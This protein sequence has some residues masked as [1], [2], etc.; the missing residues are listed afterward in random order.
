MKI[1]I[2]ISAYNV[3]AYIEKCLNSILNQANQELELIVVDDGSTDRTAEIVKTYQKQEEVEI[4]LIQ[5]VNQ[6][7]QVARQV[8]ME[9]SSGDYLLWMDSDDWLESKALYQLIQVVHK[10]PSDIICFNYQCVTSDGDVSSSLLNLEIVNDKTFIHCLLTGKLNGALW[11]KLIKKDFLIK[12]NIILPKSL[13]YGEDLA[14]LVLIST[15]KPTVFVLNDVL[16][17]YYLRPNS[18]SNSKQSAIY[19]LPESLNYVELLLSSSGEYTKELELFFYL[20]LY[21]Y[22]VILETNS[23]VKQY[24][25]SIWQRKQISVI[26]NPLFY[27]FLMRLPL[28]QKLKWIISFIKK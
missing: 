25:K 3:E 9:A 28:K 15:F 1:S 17:N 11:N 10:Y 5:Q 27:D 23:Q 8:G 26:K 13:C 22:R 20:H 6:G 2:V 7:V 19:R 18:V 21:Y 4:K 24:F 12:N 16:Y 14:S